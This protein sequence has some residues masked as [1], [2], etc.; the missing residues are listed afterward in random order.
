LI[1]RRADLLLWERNAAGLLQY[2]NDAGVIFFDYLT[3][4]MP[5]DLYAA[6][7]HRLQGDYA[8]ARASFEHSRVLLDCVMKVL[9]DGWQAHAAYGLTLA[10]LGRREEAINE[11]RWL[12]RSRLYYAGV[13]GELAENCIRILAQAGDSEEAINEIDRLLAGPSIVS[14]HTVRIDPLMDPIRDHPRFK[15]LLTKYTDR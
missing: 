4:C 1:A 7:A 9:P 12:Q 10:G 3:G 15:A 13:M 5:A 14:V 11:A 2:V 8:S 6:W